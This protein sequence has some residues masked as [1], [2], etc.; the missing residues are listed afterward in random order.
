LV[1]K[2][3]IWDPEKRI[4]PSEALLHPWVIQGIPEDVRKHHIH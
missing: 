3:L 2:C 1:K 4:T